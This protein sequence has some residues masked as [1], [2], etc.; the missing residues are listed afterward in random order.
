MAYYMY[1]ICLMEGELYNHKNKS[2]K[3]IFLT[4]LTQCK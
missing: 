2:D 3:Q 4:K 1:G